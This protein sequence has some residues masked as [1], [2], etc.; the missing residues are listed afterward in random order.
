MFYKRH[1]VLF[2]LY[3]F[4]GGVSVDPTRN[5]ALT[6]NNCTFSYFFKDYEAL[7]YVENNNMMIQNLTADLYPNHS[8]NL[9]IFSDDRGV[10]ILI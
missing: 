5:S 4:P 2:N 6:I 7:I 3:N 9:F 1:T 8:P 10:N